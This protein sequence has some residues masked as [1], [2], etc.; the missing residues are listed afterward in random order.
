[1]KTV[2]DL[3]DSKWTLPGT[4]VNSVNDHIPNLFCLC[5]VF[6]QGLMPLLEEVNDFTL[7]MIRFWYLM[8][9]VA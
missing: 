5:I 4:K 2:R 1:V 6:V 9:D 3:T 8:Y 7:N